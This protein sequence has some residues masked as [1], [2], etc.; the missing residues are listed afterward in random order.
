MR[1]RILTI[2]FFICVVA[3]VLYIDRTARV[4]KEEE[5]GYPPPL[6]PK[7]LIKEP[8]SEELIMMTRGLA[9]QTETRSGR[10]G[11]LEQGERGLIVISARQDQRIMQ[12]VKKALRERGADADWIYD[13]ELLMLEF[14]LSEEQAKQ[15]LDV[16]RL[17]ARIGT[18]FSEGVMEALLFLPHKFFHDILNTVSEANIEN[19][20]RREDNVQLLVPALKS[21]MD[22]HPEYRYTFVSFWAGGPLMRT[23][24]AALGDRFQMGWRYPNMKSLMTES[25]AFP[26]DLFRALEDKLMEVIPWIEEVKITDPEGTYVRFSVTEEEAKAWAKGAYFVNYIK[27]YPLQATLDAYRSTELSRGEEKPLIVAPSSEGVIV[28]TVNH[29]G[30]YSTMKVTVQNG[31]IQKVEGGG[32]VGEELRSLLTNETLQKAHY[33]GLPHPGFL[34]LFQGSY[35]VN[36]KTVRDYDNLPDVDRSGIL[37]WGFGVD[38]SLPEVARFAASNDLPNA[39]AFHMHNYFSTYEVKL[40]G[41][42]ETVKLVDKGQL[43][44]L[45][46]PEIKSLASKYGDPEKILAEDFIPAVPGINIPGNYWE[47]YGKD[48]IKYYQNEW[49][50]IESGTYPYLVDRPIPIF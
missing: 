23:L 34:F 33:P 35:A 43:R 20:N 29:S 4:K 16:G 3:V 30:V 1:K 36:P 17:G 22:Q 6:Y 28:G 50:K 38:S 2:A 40:R 10:L 12:A 15:K 24:R 21:Y 42:R 46:D 25:V 32:R 8:S 48:P 5:L 9:R 11:V 49:K 37:T 13:Y 14:K 26:A 31:L 19:V 18:M 7:Y 39:H 41:S 44:A 27:M 45:K 47:D